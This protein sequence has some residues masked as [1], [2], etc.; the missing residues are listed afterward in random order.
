MSRGRRVEPLRDG[1]GHIVQLAVGDDAVS[2]LDRG[3]I[4][5]EPRMLLDK[6]VGAGVYQI[7]AKPGALP[8]GVVA[9]IEYSLELKQH[10]IMKAQNVV[11]RGRIA[12]DAGMLDLVSAFVSIKKTLT[13]SGRNITFKAGRGGQDGHADLAWAT[14]HILMNEPLDGKEAPTA[15]LEIFE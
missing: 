5:T 10:M 14:M 2:P 13:T 11:R 4:G 15:T 12:F 6:G 8:G 3:D 9:K 7:M 1:F